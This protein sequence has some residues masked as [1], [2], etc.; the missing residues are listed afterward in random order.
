[1]PMWRPLSVTNSGCGGVSFILVSYN[2]KKY[3][4]TFPNFIVADVSIKSVGSVSI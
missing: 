4:L 1:M 2:N 3:R